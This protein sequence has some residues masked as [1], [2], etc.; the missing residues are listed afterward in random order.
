[1]TKLERFLAEIQAKL[2]NII[3]SF[4]ILKLNDI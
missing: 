4:T 3:K 2:L 1:L